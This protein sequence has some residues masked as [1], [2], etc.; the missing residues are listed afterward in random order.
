MR[1]GPFCLIER[2]TP[3]EVE[4]ELPADEAMIFGRSETPSLPL[5]AKGA[6]KAPLPTYCEHKKTLTRQIAQ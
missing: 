4:K 6:V 5:V 2:R 3:A 1:I